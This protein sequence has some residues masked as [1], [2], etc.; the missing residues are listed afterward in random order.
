MLCKLSECPFLEDAVATSQDCV[1]SDAMDFLCL[2]RAYETFEVN[3]C[4]PI[5][6]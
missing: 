4:R 5:P 1:R 2:E 6:R 3:G